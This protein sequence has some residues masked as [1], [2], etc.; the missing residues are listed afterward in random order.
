M[1]ARP[2]LSII[3]PVLNEAPGIVAVLEALAPLRQRGVEV[4][5]VDGGSSDD[6]LTAAAPL[7]DRVLTSPRG[8][9]RQM[10]AGAVMATGQALLFLHADTRL[11]DAADRLV[12][13]AVD[14]HGIRRHWGRFDVV[15]EGRSAWLPVIARMMNLR[16]RITGIATGDQAI[17]VSRSALKAVGGFAEIPLMEDIDLSR[18]LG[19]LSRPACLTA[20]ATTS[21]RRWETHGV[22]RMIVLMWSLRLRYF[23]GADP[24]RLALE[25]GYGQN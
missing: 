10:N 4:I 1:S 25:Y 15:I 11:P 12:A 6:T 23:L 3:M 7:S 13:D 18:R 24:A 22:W 19:R 9:A 16:S 14:P 2:A 8:R 20:R 21:G 5:V 17:F